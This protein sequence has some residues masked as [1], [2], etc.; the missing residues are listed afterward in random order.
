MR[1]SKSIITL[2]LLSEELGTGPSSRRMRGLVDLG[3]ELVDASNERPF[4]GGESDFGLLQGIPEQ[5][6]L[7]KALRR[8][9]GG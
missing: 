5:G 7:R 9:W 2:A 4:G 8:G 6:T 1:S 3:L